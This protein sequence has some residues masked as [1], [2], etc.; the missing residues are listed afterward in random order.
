MSDHETKTTTDH[1]TIRQWVEDRGG[2]PAEVEGTGDKNDPGVIRITFPNSE[3]SE[4]E[5]LGVI[6]WEDWF[7]KFD[8]AKLALLYQ[9]E[10]SDGKQ[11]MFSK[12][13]DR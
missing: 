10:T 6:N 3:H 9:E 1:A 4:H 13:V 12:L 8:E 7:A 11:S 5:N 2:Q